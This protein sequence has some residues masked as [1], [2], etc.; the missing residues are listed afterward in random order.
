[1]NDLSNTKMAQL[2]GYNGG[3]MDEAI[4]TFSNK[5]F[6][7]GEEICGDQDK[8]YLDKEQS[9]PDAKAC[10]HPQTR[11]ALEQYFNDAKQMT[12]NLKFLDADKILKADTSQ[13]DKDPSLLLQCAFDAQKREKFHNVIYNELLFYKLF[14]ALSANRLNDPSYEPIGFVKSS[15]NTAQSETDRLYQQSSTSEDAISLMMKM[16]QNIQT[17]FPLHIGLLAYYEDV[18]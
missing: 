18:M 2:Y 12:D 4:K 1:M 6:G 5:Y 9:D 8:I 17:T 7:S 13:C 10:S 15:A 14:L 3:D 11:N 16:L